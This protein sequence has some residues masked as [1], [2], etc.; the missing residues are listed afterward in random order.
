MTRMKALDDLGKGDSSFMSELKQV[1]IL[2]DSYTDRSLILIDEFGKGTC[3][4]DGL[5]LFSGLLSYFA[6]QPTQPLLVATTHLHEIFKLGLVD[7]EAGK[8]KYLRMRVV[9]EQGRLFMLYRI[10]EGLTELSH[11][12]EC[13][14]EAGLPKH[15]SKRGKQ[16]MCSSTLTSCVYLCVHL[17][18]HS[19]TLPHALTISNTR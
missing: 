3:D 18:Q 11:A 7:N 13:A 15:I 5:A 14:E 8:F 2:T 16:Q 10:E 9:R 17:H 6:K 19:L 4:Q 12:I 1:K